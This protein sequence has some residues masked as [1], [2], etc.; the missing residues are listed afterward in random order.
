[1]KIRQKHPDRVPVWLER[2]STA[3]C[4]TPHIDKIKYLVP[5]DFTFGQWHKMI[6]KRLKLSEEKGL[7]IFVNQITPP[8]SETML[9]IYDNH[10]DESGFLYMTYTLENTFGDDPL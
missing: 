4:D 6:R 10:K 7:F 3:S 9:Q 5:Y 8:F 2:A 1:M